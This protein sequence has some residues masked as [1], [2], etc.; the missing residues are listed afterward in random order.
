[1]ATPAQR[2]RYLRPIVTGEL[3]SAFAMT[4]PAPGA[5]SDPAALTTAAQ[6]VDGGWLVNG[7]KHFITG[8]DGAG[9]F[10][11]MARTSGEPG[12]LGGSHDAPDAGEPSGDGHRPAHRHHGQVHGVGI[13]NSLESP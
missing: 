4:E 12:D 11:I 2:D 8:A 1:V 5:G 9:M 7:R 6:R 13:L 3:R 10:I